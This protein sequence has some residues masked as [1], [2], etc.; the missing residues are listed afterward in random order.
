MFDH[1]GRATAHSQKNLTLAEAV[2]LGSL[3]LVEEWEDITD[4]CVIKLMEMEGYSYPVAVV[5]YKGYAVHGPHI[6][7]EDGKVYRR[8][9]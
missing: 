7:V 9:G 2:D 4:Q 1:R 3:Y 8:I 6:K 5:K